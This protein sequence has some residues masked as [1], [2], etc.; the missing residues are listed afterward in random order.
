MREEFVAEVR[1]WLGTRFRYQ[2]RD[3]KG[4]DC[5]GVIVLSLATLGLSLQITP[6]GKQVTGDSAL[7]QL[8]ANG[9]RLDFADARPGDIALLNYRGES[10]HVGIITGEGTMVHSL[11]FAKKVVEQALDHPQ[12]KPYWVGLYRLNCLEPQ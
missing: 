12:V 9:R 2:G 7:A 1:S 8:R 5:V 10:N 3:R 6:Y 11:A 4:I